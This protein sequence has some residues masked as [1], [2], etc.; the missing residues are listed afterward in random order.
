MAS[1]TRSVGSAPSVARSSLAPAFSTRTPQD[2]CDRMATDDAAPAAVSSTF[3]SL[4]QTDSFMQL[5]MDA[6]Q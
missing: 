3:V 5:A 6:T 4:S 2:V 1:R